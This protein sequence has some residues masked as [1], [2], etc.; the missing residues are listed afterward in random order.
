MSDQIIFKLEL[1]VLQVSA[2]RAGLACLI[3]DLAKR[4]SA[5]I[6]ANSPDISELEETLQLALSLHESFS[7]MLAYATDIAKAK[8]LSEAPSPSPY[9][10]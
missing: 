2:L 8:K 9:S 10:H 5:A 6:A 3:N 7:D 4:L 1:Q